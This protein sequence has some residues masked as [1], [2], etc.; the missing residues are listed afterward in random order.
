[1]GDIIKKNKMGGAC[2]C[3]EERRIYRVFVRNPAR[4]RSK[5]RWE[6]NIKMDL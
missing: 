3:M 2:S 6:D 1:M 5:H 4:K